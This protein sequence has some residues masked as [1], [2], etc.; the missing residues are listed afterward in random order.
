MVPMSAS[1][2]ERGG[3][4][5]LHSIFVSPRR[6]PRCWRWVAG[7]LLLLASPFSMANTLKQ[8]ALVKW[9][10][11]WVLSKACRSSTITHLMDADQRAVAYHKHS[12]AVAV[13]GT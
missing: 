9:V 5:L 4:G 1:Q 2:G 8:W 12:Q 7:C 11:T 3:M 6:D 10:L 13:E